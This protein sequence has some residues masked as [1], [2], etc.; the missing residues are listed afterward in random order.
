[1]YLFF[2]LVCLFILKSRW[3]RARAN[4]VINDAKPGWVKRNEPNKGMDSIFT[5]IAI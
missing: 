1:M 2:V 3:E 5:R 4:T